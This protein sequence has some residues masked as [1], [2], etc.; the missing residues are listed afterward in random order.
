MNWGEPAGSHSYLNDCTTRILNKKASR[1]LRKEAAFFLK[2]ILE[3]ASYETVAVWLL[4]THHTNNQIKTNK[5]FCVLLEK[6]GR[7]HEWHSLKASYMWI[8]SFIWL[9]TSW[10]G[11]YNT[12][13]PPLQRGKFPPMSV[14]EM[15]LNNLMV[16]FQ[17]CW[18]F[19]EFR[20]PIYCHCFQVHSVPEW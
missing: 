11:L 14:L 18:S 16:R 12:P 4:T 6:S 19:G 9:L 10:L 13:T 15:T 3:S 8:I 1:K 17:R 7:T 2:Q 5:I 20:E